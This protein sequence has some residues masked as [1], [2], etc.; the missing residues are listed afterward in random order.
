MFGKSKPPVE[1]MAKYL[2]ENNYEDAVSLAQAYMKKTNKAIKKY[3]LEFLFQTITAL[4]GV[5]RYDEALAIIDEVPN[6]NYGEYYLFLYT[7][8]RIFFN[9][10]EYDKAEEVFGEVVKYSVMSLMALQK[11]KQQEELTAQWKEVMLFTQ[12]FQGLIT[13]NRDSNPEG[14]LKKIN[15]VLEKNPEFKMALDAKNQIIES[16]L[17]DEEY[18]KKKG[19]AN[20]KTRE[21]L[22][23]FAKENDYTSVKA[24]FSRMRSSLQE[25]IPKIEKLEGKDLDISLNDM[26]FDEEALK[27][28]K[29][30]GLLGKKSI[31]KFKRELTERKPR[32]PTEKQPTYTGKVID[33]D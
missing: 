25:A 7:K 30:L 18:L 5:H 17:S 19:I 12:T 8:G 10:E 26:L 3:E 28:E 1:E 9:M 22:I 14:A 13:L 24:L 6:K 27:M 11:S 20:K 33:L 15:F 31:K 2:A 21:K 32:E 16:G 29:G 23:H 4:S